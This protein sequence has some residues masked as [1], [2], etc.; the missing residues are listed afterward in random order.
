MNRHEKSLP[1]TPYPG[2]PVLAEPAG[3]SAARDLAARLPAGTAGISVRVRTRRGDLPNFVAPRMVGVDDRPMWHGLG[4]LTVV[5]EPGD[6]LVEVR[7]R[8]SAE[9]ARLVRVRAGEIVEL[10]YWTPASIG[11]VDGLLTVAPA[12]RRMGAGIW[13]VVAGFAAMGGVALLAQAASGD[14]PGAGLSGAVAALLLIVPVAVIVAWSRV[15]RHIDRR[16]R[17]AVSHEAAADRRAA[18]TGMFLGDGDV[19]AGLADA[20]H[21]VLVVTATSEQEYVWNGIQV[22]ARPTADPHAW[23]PWP[24]LAIDGVSRPFS[25]RTWCYRLPP[26]PHELTVTAR[27]PVPVSGADGGGPSVAP[28]GRVVPATVRVEVTAGAVTRLDLRIKSRTEVRGIGGTRTGPT[29]VVRFDATTTVTP[30]R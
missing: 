21:G 27:P 26:G 29:E 24:A 30:A 25:W 28:A 9:T 19:P 22:G 5:T 20:G 23:L 2:A 10:E 17:A 4:R 11:N 6:H 1:P 14:Q 7:G 16:H 13:P 8:H 15:K 3:G 18:Q 12:R